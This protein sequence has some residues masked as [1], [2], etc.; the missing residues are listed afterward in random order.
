MEE[1][2]KRL[3]AAL[4]EKEAEVERLRARLGE[5]PPAPPRPA[6]PA[7]RPR[8]GVGL[9]KEDVERYSRQLIMPEV[10]VEGQKRLAGASVLVVGAGGLGCPAAIYLAAAGVGHLGILDDDEVDMS[11]LHRQILHT[12]A[13]RGQ[14]KASSAR[15]SAA[16]LNSSITVTAH[17]TRLTRDNALELAAPYSILL[18]ASD[19]APTRYL[20]NDVAV[21]LGK[22][23]I[24][25]SAL[26][27]E[28]QLTTYNYRGGPCYR[29][30]FPSPPPAET[31]TNCSDGGV[32]GVVT[33]IIGSLQA[34]EAIRMILGKE[35]SYA[36]RLL[37]FDGWAGTF[38][39]IKLRP[40]NPAC[41]S[42]GDNPSVSRDLLDYEE[43]CHTKACDASTTLNIL[44][45][46]ERVSSRDLQHYLG[47]LDTSRDVRDATS[48]VLDSA[49]D[50]SLPVILDVRP[51]HEFAICAIPGSVNIPMKVVG[52]REALR[53]ALV[54][55]LGEKAGGSRDSPMSLFVVCRRGNDSQIAVRAIQEELKSSSSLDSGECEHIALFE[56]VKAVK[57]LKGGL[58]AWARLHPDFPVY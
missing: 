38:R 29:C 7:D 21:L 54:A 37:L 42:C 4:R 40:R 47:R 46:V 56:H 32:L 12:E 41:A 22:P 31:V 25:G 13:R 23:L 11:N 55:A 36:G 20:L 9:S 30:L 27:A 28:G 3:R 43:F 26:R 35:D 6:A 10:G 19:N 53:A 14:T 1:E 39:A 24:S 49:T 51:A 2:L 17:E 57:D 18:D 8:P 16:A 5:Q 48:P 50:S 34:L 33:G 58:H 44:P 52:R 45:D 15:A